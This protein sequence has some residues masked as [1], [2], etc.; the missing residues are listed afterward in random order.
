MQEKQSSVETLMLNLGRHH[1]GMTS[2]IKDAIEAA[3]IIWQKWRALEKDAIV[4]ELNR[5]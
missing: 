2:K 5:N 4:L 3:R 1:L